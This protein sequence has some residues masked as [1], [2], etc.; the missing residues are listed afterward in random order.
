M[1]WR[2]TKFACGPWVLTYERDGLHGGAFLAEVSNQQARPV[3]APQ[4]PCPHRQALCCLVCA[5]CVACCVLRVVHHASC[6]LC[7]CVQVGVDGLLSASYAYGCAYKCELVA[8][9]PLLDRLTHSCSMFGL[10]ACVLYLYVCVA[11]VCGGW[12]GGRGSR[13]PLRRPPCPFL[14][15]SNDQVYCN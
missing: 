8:C 4:N 14:H 13:T 9:I 3:V 10:H 2:S 12:G 7:H 11:C 5:L 1:W 15:V 6:A